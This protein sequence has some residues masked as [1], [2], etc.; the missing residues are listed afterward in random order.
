MPNTQSR[1]GIAGTVYHQNPKQNP[2]SFPL[3]GSMFLKT[4]EE[5]YSRNPPSPVGKKWQAIELGWIPKCSMLCIRNLEKAKGSSLQ[6]GTV[7]GDAFSP[8]PLVIPPGMATVLYPTSALAL[9]CLNG[10]AR[11]TLFAVPE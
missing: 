2:A 1:V 11:Y 8:L 10:E 6:L 9:H 5:V 3:Q 7:S 4:E